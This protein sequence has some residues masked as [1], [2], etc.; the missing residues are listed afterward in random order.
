MKR[1]MEVHPKVKDLFSR[2][3]IPQRTEKWFQVRKTLITASEAAGALDIKPFPTYAGSPRANLLKAKREPCGKGVDNHFTRHG[4]QYEDEARDLYCQRTGEAAYEFGLII[5]KDYPWLGCSVDGV[6]NTGKVV[7]IKCPLSRKIKPGHVPEH[8]MPQVQI[9][10]EVCD[11]DE[12]VFIQYKPE[13]V[14]WPSP[15]EFDVTHVQRDRVWFTEVMPKLKAFVDEMQSQ[16]KLGIL[17]IPM[18]SSKTSPPAATKQSTTICHIFEEL[19]ESK[20]EPDAAEPDGGVGVDT[21][22]LA[23]LD[24]CVE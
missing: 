17:N 13:S 6:T 3:Q 10:M 14:T 12:A 4:Q 21:E 22:A 2:E 20:R 1:R 7:E 23:G 11:L 16:P 8:Y 19:Y 24:E 5:H 18:A 9:C 15:S